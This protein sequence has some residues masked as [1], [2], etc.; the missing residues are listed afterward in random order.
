MRGREGP[1]SAQQM[2]IAG[3]RETILAS[4]DLPPGVSEN[5]DVNVDYG[6]VCEVARF[7]VQTNETD[8]AVVGTRGRSGLVSTVLGST[9]RALVECLD[10]DVLMVPQRT[11]VG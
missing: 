11:G 8:L 9:A 7:H 4:L 6:D 2:E 3:E 5:L 1:A 10:C